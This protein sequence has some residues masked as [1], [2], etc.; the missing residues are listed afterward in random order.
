MIY[1][2]HFINKAFNT[3]SNKRDVIFLGSSSSSTC[4][5]VVSMAIIASDDI[6]SVSIVLSFD[7]RG[8]GPRHEITKIIFRFH[9]TRKTK[10][11]FHDF[12]KCRSVKMS[13]TFSR[14]GGSLRCGITKHYERLTMVSGLP[15]WR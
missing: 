12:H 14:F 4:I 8:G 3:W 15:V 10:F 11:H 7:S 13:E 6:S 1:S 2:L 5:L 9:E